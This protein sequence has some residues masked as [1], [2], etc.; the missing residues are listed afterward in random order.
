MSLLEISDLTVAFEAGQALRA[1][2]LSVGA[3]E[4]IGLVGES[5]SGKTMAG[6]AVMGMVPEAANVTGEIRYDG[7]PLHPRQMAPLRGREIAMI[8]QEP[9]TALN[10]LQTIGRQITEPMIWHGLAKG[11]AARARA[12]DLLREVDMPDPEARLRQYPHQ[13]SGGQR[14][15]AMIALALACGPRLVIADEPTTALDP[16][17]A[18]QILDLLARLSR[19]RE[20]ALIL[21]SHDLTAVE[22]SVERLAVLYAG[23]KVEEGPVGQVLSAP[24]HPYTQGLVAARPRLR[25]TGPRHKLPT[26]QGVVPPL[27]ELGQGCRFHGRCPIGT[28]A[29]LQARPALIEAGPNQRAACICMGVDA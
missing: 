20:M 5:G 2:S 7:T 29:C 9:M 24:A 26:I 27:A 22:R 12:L 17:R 25:L 13:L 3:G 21:I 16:V 18:E 28:D 19:E 8:F 15:R 4:R 14:Q 11:R 23:D 1:L 6:L 10:P